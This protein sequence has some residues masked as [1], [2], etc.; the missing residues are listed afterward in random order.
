M[1]IAKSVFALSYSLSSLVYKH[2]G[3]EV[4][5]MFISFVYPLNSPSTLHFEITG[6]LYIW[7]GIWVFGAFVGVLDVGLSVLVGRCIGLI[8][9]M[10]R[11][12]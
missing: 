5:L 2:S 11:M 8:S 7:Y 4:H 10:S 3:T 1:V 12:F 9:R 6:V